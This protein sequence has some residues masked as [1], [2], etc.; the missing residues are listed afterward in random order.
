MVTLGVK[1]AEQLKES[2]IAQAAAH[3]AKILAAARDVARKLAAERGTTNADDVAIELEKHG[4]D[5]TE[6]GNA[7]GSIFR[8]KDWKF[9]GFMKSVRVSRH[10]N[11]IRIWQL[12]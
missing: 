8:G 1:Q 2:G 10:R 6:L 11:Q 12:A 4:V 5:S 9:V 7:A 3:R